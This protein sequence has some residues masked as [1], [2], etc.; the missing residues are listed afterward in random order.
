MSFEDIRYDVD[1]GVATVAIDRPNRLN[2]LR[3]ETLVELAEGVHMA[4][5]DP[6]VGVVV[7]RGLGG[8]AFSAGGDQK[9]L[10]DK[11]GPDTWRPTARKFIALFESIRRCP[12]P[13]IAAVQGW[14]I[15]GGNEL[16]TFCDLTI[17]SESSRF[18]QIGPKVG[19][20]P[21]FI[22][23][24]LPR[25]VGDKRAKEIFFLC[26]Q[27]DAQAAKEM[28]MVNFVVP[29]DDF[30]GEL[31]ALCQKILDK[32]PTALR[33]LKMGVN[34]GQH[35]DEA[36]T[37]LLIEMA[38]NFFGSPEQREG[39]EAYQEKRDPDFRQYRH[40]NTEQVVG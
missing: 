15:G 24:I 21:M 10:V 25:A 36:H 9:D 37:D 12:S 11:M 8:R 27:Y 40:P 30:E 20:M 6:T 3:E 19:A 2:A 17:A 23:Q 35:F 38:T 22:T 13:V 7:I 34:H 29:D 18:G 33:V 1:E 32:S 31:D 39:T 4:S 26:E 14:A 28:G 16:A 5:D